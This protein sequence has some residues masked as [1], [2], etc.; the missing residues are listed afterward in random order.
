QRA[1]VQRLLDAGVDGIILPPPLCDS[2]PTLH[3]LEQAK[4]PVVAVAGGAPS[5]AAASVRIDDYQGACAMVRYLLDLGHRD[6]AIIKGDPKHTPAGLRATAF[7]DT[8]AEA[9]IEVPPEYVAPGLFTYR[10]GLAAAA[11]LLRQR[12]RPTAIF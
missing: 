5:Q 9:G 1:A 4:I 8:M 12:R 6:I 3:E 11:D 10:S 7:F 2:R